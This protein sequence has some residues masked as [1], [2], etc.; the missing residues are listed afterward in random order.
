M[1][2]TWTIAIECMRVPILAFS[3]SGGRGYRRWGTNSD[4]LFTLAQIPFT[5]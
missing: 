2:S 5:C 3:S 4:R 1:L